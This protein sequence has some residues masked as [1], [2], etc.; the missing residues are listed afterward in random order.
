MNKILVLLAFFSVSNSAAFGF[1]DQSAQNRPSPDLFSVVT[2]HT[3]QFGSKEVSYKAVVSNFLIKKPYG[4]VYAEAVTTSYLADSPDRARPVTFIFNGGPGS[5]STWLHMGLM[6]PVRVRVPSDAQDPGLAPYTMEQ[7][8]SALLDI[9]DLV[10]IDPIGTGYSRLAG[11][12]KPED[13]YGLEE[14]ARSV[15]DVVRAWIRRQKRWNAPVFI[16]GESFG[17]TRAAAM[18]PH[19][20]TGAEPIR[21]SGIIMISQA[22]DYTG[23]TPTNDN[24]IAYATYLP[25]L[26]AT[27][28]YHNRLS[29]RPEN[30]ENFLEEVRKFTIEEY[31]PALVKGSYLAPAKVRKLA[32]RLE[33]YT[34]F[35]REYYQLSRLRVPTGTFAKELLKDEG[36]IV[37][38]L[39]SRYR[40]QSVDIMAAT[41]RF[42]AA[43]AAISAAYSSAF[44]QYLADT[45]NV[46]LD[47]P[48]F[49]SGSEVGENWVYDRRNG[50]REPAYVNT[51]PMLA[52]AMA[53]NPSLRVLVASGYYDLITP[54]FD[55]EC[56][57]ARHGIDLSRM[58]MTYYRAGHMMYVHEPAFEELST[59]MRRFM[60]N[61]LQVD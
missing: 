7:N 9:T 26:A 2:S 18:M 5:A 39:D 21:V 6:G 33:E 36:F 15:A 47:R 48:Y 37:G 29:E 31:L 4:E 38:R 54:F 40:A 53:Q 44:R 13:V 11:E 3:G 23:S 24:L 41:P 12:G 1:D 20:Q 61:I 51:A 28:W 27:A 55:A 19:L 45:L 56:T 30:L 25:S 57:V 35:S 14:D 52:D 43:S 32:A 34:G 59:D 49:T 8:P 22:M 16:A 58:T 60:T 50:Y 42:D 10:F 46:S 17:T